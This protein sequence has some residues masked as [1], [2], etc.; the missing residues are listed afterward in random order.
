MGRPIFNL[1]K[2]SKLSSVKSE[3]ESKRKGMLVPSGKETGAKA[4]PPTE[5]TVDET[6]VVSTQPDPP[7]P[8]SVGVSDGQDAKSGRDNSA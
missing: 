4:P 2:C 7:M 3:P 6:V 5:P 1:L 8:S